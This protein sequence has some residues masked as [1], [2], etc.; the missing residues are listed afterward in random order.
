MQRIEHHVAG[1]I[2]SWLVCDHLLHATD[3]DAGDEALDPD[4]AVSD[5]QGSVHMRRRGERVQPEFQRDIPE[6]TLRAALDK[7]MEQR[8][9]S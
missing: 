1:V 3:D 7:L 8:E 9:K 4:R 6:S 5:E 2:G